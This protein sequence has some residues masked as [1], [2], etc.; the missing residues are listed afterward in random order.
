MKKAVF[1]DRDGIINK[2]SGYVFKPEDFNFIDGVF[3]FCRTAQSKGYLLIIITNQSG[4]AR[5]YFTEQDFHE[6]NNWMLEEFKKNGVNIT[7]VYYCPYHPDY[8]E[9]IYKQDSFDRKPNPGMIQKAQA[10]HDIDLSNSIIIGDKD[11]D[12]EAGRVA[13]VGKLILIKGQYKITQADDVIVCESLSYAI[14]LF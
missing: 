10:E 13:G 7:A 14:N 9:G 6:L 2:D 3:G 5:G 8:G 12:V 1:L 4:I 11:S